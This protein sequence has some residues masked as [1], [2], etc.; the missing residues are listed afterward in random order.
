MSQE[1]VREAVSEHYRRWARHDRSGWLSL[2]HPDVLID[3]PV[4]EPTLHGLAGAATVYD[5]MPGWTI[6]PVILQVHTSEA[7][8]VVTNVG[9]GP[10]GQL[11]IVHTIEIWTV[12][13]DGLIT[14]LRVY[15][16]S[17]PV[18][19]SMPS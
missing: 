3:D 12:D 19:F 13:D 1:R 15:P 2:F 4:G 18:P 16:Y 8:I 11:S 9:D 7:A 17:M 5:R 6:A 10:N 14:G